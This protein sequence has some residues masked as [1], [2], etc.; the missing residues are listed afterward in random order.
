RDLKLV[1]FESK[2][3]DDHEDFFGGIVSL[4]P[5][6]FDYLEKKSRTWLQVQ[7]TALGQNIVTI[8]VSALTALAIAWLLDRLGPTP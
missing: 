4:T 5:E 7:L 3:F 8:G 2:K 6:G 1:R